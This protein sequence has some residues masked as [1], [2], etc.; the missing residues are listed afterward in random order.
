MNRTS[1]HELETHC[2]TVRRTPHTSQADPLPGCFLGPTGVKIALRPAE[3]NCCLNSR[4]HE[5]IMQSKQMRDPPGP[6]GRTSARPCPSGR[7]HFAQTR[8]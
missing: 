4:L 3:S 2:L 5:F 8:S 1:I 7:L 6:Y